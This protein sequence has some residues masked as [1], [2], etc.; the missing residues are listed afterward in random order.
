[1]RHFVFAFIA[2]LISSSAFAQ[3]QAT[4]QPEEPLKI[5]V[6]RECAICH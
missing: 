5:A 4:P 2:V 1:M 6:A 3:Q